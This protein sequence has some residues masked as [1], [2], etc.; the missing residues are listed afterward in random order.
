MLILSKKS[1]WVALHFQFY[2]Y[3]KSFPVF[4]QNLCAQVANCNLYTELDFLPQKQPS[5]TKVLLKNHVGMHNLGRNTYKN[6]ALK[7]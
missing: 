1:E 7:H 2:V 4:E 5:K 6:V 3:R